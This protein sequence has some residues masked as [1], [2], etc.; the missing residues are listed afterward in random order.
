MA[1]R[2]VGFFRELRHGDSAGPSL[3][4]SVGQLASPHV[5]ELVG[6]L[7]SAPALATTGSLVDDVLD[8]AQKGVARLEVATDGEWV[9]PRDL[10]YY[11]SRYRVGLPAD[12]IEHIHAAHGAPPSLDHEDFDRITREYLEGKRETD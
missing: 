7:E 8:G 12:F 10:A 11:V 3:R 4:A 1:L 9:W 2:S 6:Y 5:P